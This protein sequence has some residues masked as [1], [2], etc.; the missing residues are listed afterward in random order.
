MSRTRRAR[1]SL[2]TLGRIAAFVLVMAVL[3][4][5]AF[6]FGVRPDMLRRELAGAA[7][8]QVPIARRIIVYRLEAD[9]PVL[10]RFSQP[11][12]QARIVTVPTVGPGQ[13][14]PGESWTYAFSIELLDEAG[15][16]LE[17]RQAFARA[18]MFERDGQRIGAYWFFRNRD[19]LPATGDEVRIGSERPFAAI[20]LRATVADSEVLAI[21]V[22][23]S[24]RRPLLAMAADSAFARFSPAD[25][26][27]L[28]LANAFPPELLTA[29]ERRN[30]A[31][32]QWKPVGPVGIE[33]RDYRMDVLYEEVESAA[34]AARP[35]D[36]ADGE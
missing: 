18:G 16:V 22:R 30:I 11:L 15:A 10:F 33:G 26:R 12:T 1:F 32:N 5:G 27:R 20:R 23:V 3:A 9:R 19:D 13:A 4:L 2:R 24:E 29:E 25:R 6:A 7:D 21:S 36:R 34:A 28:A 31:I 8:R 35:K 14:S 17:T